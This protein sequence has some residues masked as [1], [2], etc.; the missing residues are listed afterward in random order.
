[1]EGDYEELD[2]PAL[3]NAWWCAGIGR[4][5]RQQEHALKHGLYTREA[6]EERRQPSAD[7]AIAD[8][9]PTTSSDRPRAL[10][11]S[12]G[13][14]VECSALSCPSPL[15]GSQVAERE[16]LLAD[17]PRRQKSR[18]VRVKLLVLD[19]TKSVLDAAPQVNNDQFATPGQFDRESQKVD[20]YWKVHLSNKG[21]N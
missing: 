4:S 2:A 21:H 15:A 13:K 6:I 19:T 10:S 20:A 12:P 3:P 7:A 18:F 8:A 14:R 5:A 16:S 17:S 9:D 11:R 1:M